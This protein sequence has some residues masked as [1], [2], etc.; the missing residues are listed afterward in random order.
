MHIKARL[1][2]SA[3]EKMVRETYIIEKEHLGYNTSYTDKNFGRVPQLYLEFFENR[4]KLKPEARNL[5]YIPPIVPESDLHKNKI[6]RWEPS[7]SPPRSGRKEP[8]LEEEHDAISEI[9][10]DRA[11]SPALSEK[12]EYESVTSQ[13]SSSSSRVQ[14]L[15]KRTKKYATPI[16]PRSTTAARDSARATSKLPTISELREKNRLGIS[17]NPTDIL[18]LNAEEE[19][20]KRELL[21]KF[22]ILKKSYPRSQELMP[23]F[24]MHSSYKQMKDKYDELLKALSLDKSV[25]NYKTYLTFVFMGMEYALGKFLKLDMKGFAE[26]QMMDVHKYESMLIEIGEKNYVPT[27]KQWPVWIRLVFVILVQTALF[28]VG[29]TLFSGLGAGV[30]GT[31]NDARAST[32]PPNAGPFNPKVAT[33]A[34][35]AA[36]PAG[37]MR[38]PIQRA[39]DIA[40]NAASPTS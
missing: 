15:L 10:S 39:D 12:S 32:A 40:K 16:A 23:E 28:I 25:E 7:Q 5:E 8:E 38:G 14:E 11:A 27:G 24:T 2:H 35:P 17:K 3:A 22:K 29:K 13:K 1:T 9:G 36:R 33:P 4:F 20:L 18:P 37:R 34:A 26:Q 30:L 19:D 31:V 6:I 21:F